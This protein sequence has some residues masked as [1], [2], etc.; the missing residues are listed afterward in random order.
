MR[1]LLNLDN[2][3]AGIRVKVR[4]CLL[5]PSFGNSMLSHF[6]IPVLLYLELIYSVLT[7]RRDQAQ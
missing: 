4:V 3:F 5:L 2:D 7:F 1:T 6:L